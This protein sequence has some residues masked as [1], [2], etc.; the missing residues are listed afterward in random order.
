LTADLTIG[1]TQVTKQKYKIDLAGQQAECEA[2][3]L[4]IMKLV[5][6]MNFIDRRE[7]GVELA[8]GTPVEIRITVTERCKYTTMLEVSQLQAATQWST[9]PS[10]VLRVYHD[11]QMAEV[12]AFERHNRLRPRYEYPN[13]NMYHC[14]EKAQLNQFLGEWLSHCLHHGHALNDPSETSLC[15]VS[16]K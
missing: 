14:D 15:Q 5:P 11:A 1:L 4:R 2:N 6:D 9:A 8:G 3:Y 16:N 10:F 12:I 13:T 7:F